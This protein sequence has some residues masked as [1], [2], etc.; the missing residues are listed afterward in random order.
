MKKRGNGQRIAIGTLAAAVMLTTAGCNSTG[1]GIIYQEGFVEE[2]NINPCVYGPP[3][4]MGAYK[5]SG[6]DAGT[7][8]QEPENSRA[9]EGPPPGGRPSPHD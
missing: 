6:D 2:E 7:T 5:E 1:E 9:Y 4:E 8:G 3:E